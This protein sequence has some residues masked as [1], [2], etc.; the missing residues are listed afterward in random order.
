MSAWYGDF[1]SDEERFAILDR[2]HELGET[3]WD[4]ADIYQDSEDLVG[5]WFAR[6][7]KRNEIFLS[8]KFAVCHLAYIPPP[9]SRY[10]L[11]L[12]LIVG[13]QF[14]WKEGGVP[15]VTGNAAYVKEAC[16]KSLKRLGVDQ[17]DLYY[18][19]R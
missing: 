8:T 16:A 4:S 19:H 7:G 5:K 18:Y 15:T 6:T 12:K 14:Q 1:P 9:P 2:A 10:L 17:I 11:G 13:F 3:F